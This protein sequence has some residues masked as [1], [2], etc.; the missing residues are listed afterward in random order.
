[1]YATRPFR[2]SNLL[3]IPFLLTSTLPIAAQPPSATPTT[4]VLVSLTI[5]PE[6]DR[7]QVVKV[8][9]EE[10]RETVRLYLNGKIREWYSRSDGKGV[11]FLM[12]CSSIAEARALMDTLPLS[13]ANFTNLEFTPIGPLRPLGLLLGKPEAQPSQKSN[14]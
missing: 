11:I 1:M 9:P 8:L 7:A 4:A 10:V 5:K 13:K 12:N 6:I 2:F 3:A 14:E